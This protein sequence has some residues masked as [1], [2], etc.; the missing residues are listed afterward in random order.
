MCIV[1]NIL[2][3]NDN[4]VCLK[5][6]CMPATYG[7]VERKKSVNLQTTNSRYSTIFKQSYM[8]HISI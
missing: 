8:S 3:T 4:W 2:L 1:G 6:S 5:T 7:N